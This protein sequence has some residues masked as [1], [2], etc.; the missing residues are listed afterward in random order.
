MAKDISH[1]SVT[2]MKHLLESDL[3]TLLKLVVTYRKPVDEGSVRAASAILRRWM[4][5]GLLGKLCRALGVRATLPAMD[6][7]EVIRA[8]PFVPDVTYFMTGGVRFNGAAVSGHYVSDL[9]YD[10]KPRLPIDRMHFRLM[11]LGEFKSQKRLYHRG[12]YFSCDEIIKFVANKL[13]G[14]HLDESRNGL[15][16]RMEDATR[17]FTFGGPKSNIT[18]GS[19]GEQHLVVEPDAVEPLH[20]FHV[21]IIAAGTS[22]LC[23]HLD[24][25]Q[26]MPLKVERSLLSRIDGYLGIK[27]RKWLRSARLE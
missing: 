7:D 20:G 2:E 23:V 16:E 3:D 22:L 4:V 9:P 10:G 12:D 26:L 5:E 1:E 24:G 13:G 15:Y 21:E 8:L 17:A 14:V 18:R 11:K 19:P 27:H 25:V 6:N